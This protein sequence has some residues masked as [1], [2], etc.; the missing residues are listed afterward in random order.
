MWMRAHFFK[1][2]VRLLARL[3]RARDSSESKELFMKSRLAGGRFPEETLLKEAFLCP[4][5]SRGEL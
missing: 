4:V 5:L 1:L 3:G 2:D